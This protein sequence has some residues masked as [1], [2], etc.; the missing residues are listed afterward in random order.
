MHVVRHEDLSADPVP[1]FGALYGALRLPFDAET[2]RTIREATSGGGPERRVA[3]S[4]TKGGLSRT[5]FR[6][7]DSR[8]NAEKWKSALSRTEIDR[9]R[10]LTDD[11]AQR[12]YGA[13]AW[14]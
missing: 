11:V 14:G 3:W 5:A 9:I 2:E 4:F 6:P 12:F 13:A 7:L 8:A 10:V 1:G